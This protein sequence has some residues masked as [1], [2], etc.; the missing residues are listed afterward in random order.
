M[1][2]G[3]SRNRDFAHVAS[4][5]PDARSRIVKR[6]T[7][8]CEVG[9]GHMG[10]PAVDI[11]NSTGQFLRPAAEC[12]Y[13]VTSVSPSGPHRVDQ[14]G[15]LDRMDKVIYPADQRRDPV[16]GR[17]DVAFKWIVSIPPEEVAVGKQHPAHAQICRPPLEVLRF[18]GQLVHSVRA[19]SARKDRL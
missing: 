13:Y 9:N 19:I 16:C 12:L 14:A 3:R 8:T 5:A 7:L 15:G 18:V 2:R 1:S 11:G 4:Q 6:D 17:G 10:V